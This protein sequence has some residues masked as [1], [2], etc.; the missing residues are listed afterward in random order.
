MAG[1]GTPPRGTEAGVREVVKVTKARTKDTSGTRPAE[2][3]PGDFRQCG[4]RQA[5]TPAL[6]GGQSGAQRATPAP[7]SARARHGDAHNG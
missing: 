7:P 4:G 5:G 3:A 2:T 1:A 6:S